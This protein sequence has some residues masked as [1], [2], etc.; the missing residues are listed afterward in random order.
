MGNVRWTDDNSLT[1]GQ[2]L[3][4]HRKVMPTALERVIWGFGD[5]STIPVYET[6][7]G[8]IGALICWENRM[9]LLRTALYGKASNGSAARRVHLLPKGRDGPTPPG[10]P[11]KEEILFPE[12]DNIVYTRRH[13]ANSTSKE[14]TLTSGQITQEN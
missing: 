8:K 12:G 3:G 10:D 11:P 6:P 7:I 2:Y 4:K 14:T 9:P 1:A 5:G 13:E